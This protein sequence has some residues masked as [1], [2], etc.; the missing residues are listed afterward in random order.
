VVPKQKAFTAEPYGLGFNEDDVDF[1]RFVNALLDQM[2]TD[3]EW[4]RIYNKWLRDALGPA[5][6]PPR[7]VYGRT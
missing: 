7:A 4:T 5:P 6:S 3:G 1:V 2:R